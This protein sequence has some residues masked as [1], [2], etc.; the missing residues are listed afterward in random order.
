MSEEIF[1]Q[2]VN[3]K[4]NWSIRELSKMVKEEIINRRIIEYKSL[5]SWNC[6]DDETNLHIEQ[7]WQP[8]GSISVCY[9]QDEKEVF[10]AQ[11][12]VKYGE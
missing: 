10:Y 6:I 12:M 7:G 1:G 2:V 8:F 3:E 9:N 11:A 4:S 5:I